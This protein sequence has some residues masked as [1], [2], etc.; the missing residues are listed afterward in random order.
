MGDRAP[1][2]RRPRRAAAV[3]ARGDALSD[4]TIRDGVDVDGFYAGLRDLEDVVPVEGDMG[5]RLVVVFRTQ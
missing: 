4:A 3:F 1:R 2:R 5:V